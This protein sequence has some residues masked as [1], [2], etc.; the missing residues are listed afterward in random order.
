[1][2]VKQ[3]DEKF[4]NWQWDARGEQWEAGFQA[5]LS[6]FSKN[7][8]PPGPEVT[9][10]ETGTKLDNWIKVNKKAFLAG[11]ITS[12]FTKDAMEKLKKIPGWLDWADEAKRLSL[13]PDAKNPSQVRALEK[14]LEG[15]ALYRKE[16]GTIDH[17]L[18]LNRR[19][20]VYNGFPLGQ[21]ANRYRTLY[22]DG[23]LPD[24]IIAA[25]ESQ[26]GWVWN[27]LDNTW[28]TYFQCLESYVKTHGKA[29]VSQGENHNGLALGTWVARQRRI[30]K[31]NASGKLT[32]EQVRRLESL[33]GWLWDASKTR[34]TSG[35]DKAWKEKY[36]L[37]EA[38]ARRTG[39]VKPPVNEKIDGV[40]LGRW[41]A[42]QRAIK[43]G[44]NKAG[45]LTP[46]E[47]RLLEKLPGWRW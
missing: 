15:L 38:Y 11:K 8:S 3:I 25:L 23:T 45:K 14:Y 6:W 34:R 16:F 20:F 41:V 10:P 7:D 27:E 5:A 39:S 33:P 4:E 18:S 43:K 44:V 32:S 30:K 1:V 40:F 2:R 28:E 13:F 9:I 46:D 37:L 24:W 26:D 21:A 47:I 19:S 36:D 42:V 17:P 31:G 12:V 22:K 35:R 29:A